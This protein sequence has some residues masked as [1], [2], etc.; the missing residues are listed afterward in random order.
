MK[1][2]KKGGWKM[3]NIITRLVNSAGKIACVSA[4]TLA[5]ASVNNACVFIAY[6]P[7]VPHELK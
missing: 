5:V 1:D 7:D 6:Q 2:Y 4:M 3:K